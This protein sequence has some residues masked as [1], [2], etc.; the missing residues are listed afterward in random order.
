MLKLNINKK[1][2]AVILLT[3]IFP[4]SFGC[5]KQNNSPSVS[6]TNY[7]L[8]TLVEITIYDNPS[9]DIFNKAFDRIK[10][11]EDKMTIN[12]DTYNEDTYNIKSEVMNINDNSGQKYVKVSDDTFYVIEKGLYYSN[13]SK[14]NFDITIGPIVKLWNIGT[15]FARVPSDTE[16]KNNLKLVNYKDVLINKEN[17]EVMLKREGMKIDLGSIAKGYAA[18]EV[19][20]ILLDN[21]IK[22]AIINLGGNIYALG[23][24]ID[25]NPWAI[26]IQN[27]FQK[28]GEPLGIVNVINKSV[29]TSGIYERYFEVE[30][31]RYHHILSPFTG[32][33][34]ENSIAGVSIITDNSIDADG[35][36]TTLFTLGIEKGLDLA[37]QINGV[38][39]IFITKDNEIYMTSGIK[40]NFKLIDD[41]FKIA[42]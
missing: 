32:Y 25:G 7:L 19:K 29:V 3:L 5:S 27:P 16:I 12:E 34:V 26:G 40:S 39:A 11:I 30:G 9:D 20:K 22:H 2:I 21:G 18:D 4:F 24:K 28:R 1:N 38:E 35:L 13:L 10:D 41:N 8:G 42:N 15:E 6:K 23:S 37:E 17:K 33:P 31:K 36:S 14:G